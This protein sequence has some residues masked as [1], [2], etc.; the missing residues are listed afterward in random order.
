[1]LD[2]LYDLAAVASTDEW[3]RKLAL[4]NEIYTHTIAYTNGGGDN[5]LSF[6]EIS[7]RIALNEQLIKE[8]IQPE[9]ATYSITMPNF[10][11][12]IVD[13]F[14]HFGA[15]I[16]LLLMIGETL[17]SEYEQHSIS[18]LFTQPLKKTQ[19]IMSK[20]WSAVV[21]YVFMTGLVLLAT[22]VIGLLFGEKGT[23]NY[24]VLI[25]RDGAIEFINLTSYMSK[26]IL[27]VSVVII[28]VIP[29]YLLYSLLLKQTLATLAVLL[30]TL[31]VGYGISIFLSGPIFTWLNP[32]SNLLPSEM[33]LNQNGQV[34]YQT[35]PISIILIIL[36]YWI[37]RRKIKTSKI[38]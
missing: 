14:I 31:L 21:L 11:K 26:G 16:I 25:E 8:G 38:N 34:W 17:A 24:P 23:F 9:H 15:L 32:L 27:L 10:M 20:F 5:P 28:M 4:Q 37:A 13:L 1:M 30:G 18:L 7:N 35:V 3:E 19:I 36:F 6:K 2:Q 29:L 33:I 12:Q 22:A